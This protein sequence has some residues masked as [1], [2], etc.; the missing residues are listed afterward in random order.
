VKQF[1][2]RHSVR[3]DEVS[4]C[5]LALAEACNNAIQNVTPE[6]QDLAIDIR[7]LCSPSEIE[8]QITD[9][10]RGFN[11]PDKAELPNLD[12]EH[13][14]GVFFIQSFM[15]EANYFRGSDENCLIMRKA[16]AQRRSSA[17]LAEQRNEPGGLH[18]RLA[19]TQR[20][21]TEMAREL[22]FRSETL[23]AICR[24]S[25]DLGRSNDLK[26][27]SER[28]LNDLLHIAA[29]EWFVVRTIGDCKEE[30]QA[31][32]ASIDCSELAPVNFGSSSVEARSAET[33]RDFEFGAAF[34]LSAE[35]P[36]GAHFA[37]RR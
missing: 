8:V 16:R 13:G 21:L 10:T 36:L 23:T 18:S 11:W 22:C 32:V 9:H 2:E 27:F 24:C 19:E 37:G 14:R 12:N 4:A 7:V 28:L 30:L 3:A 34:P 17:A 15:D 6:G 31:F 20:A 35:D 1:L 5:E 29:A 25:A 26:G 33:A